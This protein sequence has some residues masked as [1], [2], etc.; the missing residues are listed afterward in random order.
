VTALPKL[1]RFDLQI[2]EALWTGGP[3][4]IREIQ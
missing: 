2:M 4:S 1:R 3:L